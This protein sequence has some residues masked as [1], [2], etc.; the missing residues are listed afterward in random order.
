M[1]SARDAAAESQGK[2]I[3]PSVLTHVDARYPQAALEERKHG[4]VTLAVTVDVDGHV[5]SVE[6]LSSGGAALDEAA[7]VAARQWTFTP[8]T[9]NG[10]PVASRIRIPFHFAPPEPPP[11]LLSPP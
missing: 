8:A 11:E 10:V 1:A 5:S 4:D 7:I 2:V 9:R 3:P 6:V